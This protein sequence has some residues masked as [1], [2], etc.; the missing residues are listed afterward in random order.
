METG[1]APS[2]PD[3]PAPA[4]PWRLLDVILI[5]VGAGAGLALALLL[6]GWLAR[7]GVD[8]PFNPTVATLA[9]QGM[10]M[11]A[12]V[13]AG[14]LLRRMSWAE[15]GLRAAA[16]WWFL[17]ALAAA[18]ALLPIRLVIG[19]ALQMLIDPTMQNLADLNT[20]IFP[21]TSFLGF[22]LL[23]L[24]GGLMVPLA[25]ELF[26]RGVIYG[27]LRRHL[28]LW[29]AMGISALLFGAAHLYL[30]TAAAAFV[31]GVALAYTYEKSRSLWVPIVIHVAN[32][33]TVFTLAYLAMAL[34]RYLGMDL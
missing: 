29:P 33:M 26:F 28:S 10:T 20:A 15:A 7:S 1:E 25:E 9:V 17:V 2:Q 22:L 8:G 30:P 24:F 23:L 16:W 21:D 4:R 11:A 5:A 19:Y 27:W 34:A 14:I 12:A 6:T 18:L 3:A 31:I 13:L 32:N